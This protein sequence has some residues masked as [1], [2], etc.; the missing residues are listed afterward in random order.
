MIKSS[1][2]HQNRNFENY[3]LFHFTTC[4]LPYKNA[5]HPQNNPLASQK[6][7]FDLHSDRLHF[8]APVLDTARHP[9]VPTLL[10]RASALCAPLP[11]CP[12][13]GAVGWY[14]TPVPFHP[15]G[16]RGVQ[17]A[18]AA[19]APSGAATVELSN[20]SNSIIA[21]IL[22][23][24]TRSPPPQHHQEQQQQP[25]QEPEPGS[26]GCSQPPAR[27]YLHRHPT[28][29]PAPLLP[30]G[31]RNRGEGAEGSR[32]TQVRACWQTPHD[33]CAVCLLCVC[34]RVFVASFSASNG[35]VMTIQGKHVFRLLFPISAILYPLPLLH[36]SR[37]GIRNNILKGCLET[38][39]LGHP[40]WLRVLNGCASRIKVGSSR[41][42][43]VDMVINNPLKKM[44]CDNTLLSLPTPQINLSHRVQQSCKPER[45]AIA[46]T[47]SLAVVQQVHFKCFKAR[48]NHC[49]N[50]TII[51]AHIC[52]HICICKNAALM[53]LYLLRRKI[54]LKDVGAMAKQWDAHFVSVW[55]SVNAR[56]KAGK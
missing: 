52:T 41:T 33:R 20:H 38:K 30:S 49:N 24:L 17:G 48:L 10:Q 29:A 28:T 21:S 51:S 40:M 32:T 13:A 34:V 19:V 56:K 54:Y 27:P 1:D 53:P 25:W 22:L 2:L 36:R 9:W 39:W 31:G 14:S 26:R 15:F 35:S 6:L 46:K 45:C 3:S 12:P 7:L 8:H 47:S 43:K 11:P 42:A 18:G 50:N 5:K 23:L 16:C 37:W 44:S 4:S 55:E